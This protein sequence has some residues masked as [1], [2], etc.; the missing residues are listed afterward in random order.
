MLLAHGGRTEPIPEYIA[1]AVADT[2]R[3]EFDRLRDA[4]RKPD[5][6]I[7]FA[8]L[9]PGD[10]VANFMPGD[11]YFSRV[12][13]K[14]VGESGHVYEISVPRDPV[15]EATEPLARDCANVSTIALKMAKRPAPELWSA[16]DD[17]GVVYEYWSF[18]PPAEN[19]AAPEPLDVIWT[20]G[21]Y[22][23]LLT[24]AFGSPNMHVV[25]RA[26]FNALKP[27]GILI[28][29]DHAAATRSGIR[30]T[31]N[32]HRIDPDHVKRE[33]TAAGFEYVSASKVLRDRTDDHAANAHDMH[34]ATDR[35]LIKFRKP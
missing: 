34:D 16:S 1:E 12:F 4:R 29:E 3:P 26:L 15:T 14:V 30:D 35:F 31:A 22:H 28:I 32:L 17:P 24:A 19:F 25:N 27:G 18:S 23:D 13:C 8:D 9:R 11:G 2:G 20:S 10:K 6:V 21:S 7:A 33:V 5:Q